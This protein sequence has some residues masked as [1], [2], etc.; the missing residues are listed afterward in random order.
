MKKSRYSPKKAAEFFSAKLAFTTGP[1]EVQTMLESDQPA[2]IID[3]RDPGDFAQ[4][5]IPG[6][7]N[8]PHARW[9]TETGL[10]KERLNILYCYN[11]QCHLA[12]MAALK[13]ARKGYQVMEMEGGWEA[14][15]GFGL[16]V[17]TLLTDYEAE[18]A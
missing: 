1:I 9:E 18:A 2:T 5:H 12:A 3:L 11:Q 7:I 10:S 17:N 13:F 8:L 15:K 14:W 16:T 4:G 6:A